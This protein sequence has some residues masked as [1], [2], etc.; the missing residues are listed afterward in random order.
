MSLAAR[1]ARLR[2]GFVL[3]PG[4]LA[5]G[6]ALP[7]EMWLAAADRRRAERRADA[8]IELR[9][10]AALEEQQDYG[11][12]AVRADCQLAD[13]GRFDVVYLPALWRNPATLRNQLAPLTPWLVEQ[14]EG[15][16]QI[17]AVGTG[18][19]LLADT[20]LLDGRAA[21]TH[22]YNFE[23][24][25]RDYPAVDLKRQFFITQAGA[26][27]C[28]ASINSLADVSVHLIER[29]FDRATAQHVE[30]N[31]SHEIR[32]TYEEYRYM[33]GGLA[34]LADEVVVEA[35]LWIEANVAAQ[36]T[37]AELAARLGVSVR[38]LDR[39][40]RRASGASPRAFWQQRRVRLAKELLEKTNLTIGEIA[41]RVGYQDAGHFARLFER[42]LSVP[43]S[44]Y[45][46]TVRAKLFQA[47][48]GGTLRVNSMDNGAAAK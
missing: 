46:Q 32:R 36:L 20:G 8:R 5:T 42:E 37:V 40:F 24:F 35:Q 16:A 41:Y 48:L 39:R 4:M 14:Y 2:I 38:T 44:E 33:D 23:R 9:L 17:A 13:A 34:P 18:V 19:S 12:L 25:E 31:F 47:N 45:R 28:A 22:W 3:T 21:T 6:T 29:T 30:R 10:I 1:H 15:G 27:Y 43:P 26:L 7:Y 11:R